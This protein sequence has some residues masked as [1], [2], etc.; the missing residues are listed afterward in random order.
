VLSRDEI[1][2]TYRIPPL[3]RAVSGSVGPRGLEHPNL[4]I[5]SSSFLPQGPRSVGALKEPAH[6]ARAILTPHR[7]NVLVEEVVPGQVFTNRRTSLRAES[8]S[9]VLLGSRTVPGDKVPGHG[10]EGRKSM[11][12]AFKPVCRRELAGGF[13]SRPPPRRERF[14]SP[15][16]GLTQERG[17]LTAT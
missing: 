17:I 5:K 11:G 9:Q 1:V 16:R 14:S 7:G 15:L 10:A 12:P 13:D 2:P 8:S 6:H 3:V 4:R